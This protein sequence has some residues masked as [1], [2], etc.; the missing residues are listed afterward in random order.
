LLFSWSDFGVFGEGLWN[1]T[2]NLFILIKLLILFEILGK[3]TLKKWNVKVFW[4]LGN[5]VIG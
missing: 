3:N 2:K 5:W 1:F 4:G